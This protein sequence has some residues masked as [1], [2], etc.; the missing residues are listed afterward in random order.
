MN[1]NILLATTLMAFAGAPAFAQATGNLGDGVSI[2]VESETDT[3][4]IIQGQGGPLEADSDVGDDFAGMG[5]VPTDDQFTVA[6][7]SALVGSAVVGSDGARL[8]EV[9]EVRQT[10]DGFIR[11]F[12]NVDQSIDAMT[13][14]V[15]VTLPAGTDLGA[16]GE[17]QIAMSQA[18]F[19]S[20]VQSAVN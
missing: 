15:A 17:I 9:V 14:R 20:A 7:D 6:A 1:R 13:Q 4:V 16:G 18:D 3:G 11:L 8:G 2:G 12:V 19:T 10:S 5:A